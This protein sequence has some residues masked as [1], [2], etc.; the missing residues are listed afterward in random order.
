MGA[1]LVRVTYYT[2]HS[3]NYIKK[4]INATLCSERA[5]LTKITAELLGDRDVQSRVALQIDVGEGVHAH[6]RELFL[7][8]FAQE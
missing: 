6:S 4:K 3:A 8:L 1:M 2:E 7:K 5:D